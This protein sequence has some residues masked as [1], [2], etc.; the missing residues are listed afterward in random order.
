MLGDDVSV[1]AKGGDGFEGVIAGEEVGGVDG[2]EAV[3]VWEGG[4]LPLDVVLEED[5]DDDEAF[6]WGGGDA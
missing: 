3:G 4:G 1:L 6:G 5:G 2:P